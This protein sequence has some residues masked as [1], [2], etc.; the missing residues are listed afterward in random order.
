MN[1]ILYSTHCPQ[2]IVLENLLKQVGISYDEEN[3]TEKMLEMGFTS[4]PKLQVDDQVMD[5][6][7]AMLWIKSYENMEGLNE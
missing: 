4:V 2:C 5:M 1:I 7:D 6:K 3:D